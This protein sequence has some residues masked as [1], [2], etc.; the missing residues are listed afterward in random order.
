MIK[1]TYNADV[2]VYNL[3]PTLFCHGIFHDKFLIVHIATLAEESCQPLKCLMQ[4]RTIVHCTIHCWSH[5]HMDGLS[6]HCSQ[7]FSALKNVIH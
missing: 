6:T 1:L 4:Y 3:S 5:G 7:T 2:S